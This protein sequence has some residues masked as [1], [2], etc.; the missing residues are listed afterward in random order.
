MIFPLSRLSSVLDPDRSD[1]SKLGDI[2]CEKGK[3]LWRAVGELPGRAGNPLRVGFEEVKARQGHQ[4]IIE[5]IMRYRCAV[6]SAAI[7]RRVQE[8]FQVSL[9]EVAKVV[10]VMRDGVFLVLSL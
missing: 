5:R 6:C 2:L 8:L 7:K 3:V 9:P 4:L 10:P 1:T